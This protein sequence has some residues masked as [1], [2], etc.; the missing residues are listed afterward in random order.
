MAK[1][2]FT[3]EGSQGVGEE[4]TLT[5]SPPPKHRYRCPH[6]HEWRSSYPFIITFTVGEFG[7]PDFQ[8]VKA[9]LCPLCMAK[10]AIRAFSMEDLGEVPQSEPSN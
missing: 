7:S 10:A 4:L 1:D 3:L 5:I 2:I 9:L 6:G 8:E